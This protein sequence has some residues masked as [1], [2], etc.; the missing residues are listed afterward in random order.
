MGSTKPLRLIQHKKEAL[1]F[2]SF[3]S[4]GY[5]HVF[6]P[7]QYTEDM[8]DISLE[9]AR[10]HSRA[11]KVVDVGG[12]TGFT[13]LGVVRYVD[14]ENVTLLDQSPHQL[15]KARRKKALR[16][17]KIM[18]GD[19]EDLPFPTDTFDRY[20]SAGSIE[21]WPD[22]QRGIREAYRVL[23]ADGVACMIGP[24]RPTFWLS[25]FFADMWM[26]FPTEEEY[27]EWF[28]RAGFKDVELTRIGPR[29]YR[30]ARR[31]GLVIGCCVTGI[32]TQN[33]DSPLRLG[34]KAEDVSKPH[35]NPIFVFFRFLIGTIC[36]TYFFLVPIY[37][38]IKDKIVP[39]GRPI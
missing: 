10:L 2:Y 35:V 13:T 38:W 24:V 23:S 39:Q 26:L 32:K 33:G 16:G 3:I 20:V 4:F 18:E 30:G 8:R 12:G 7:G 37:M 29:W 22:P 36:A 31:H 9:H 11:L 14:P 28:E 21:Y 1:W 15:D 25:R 17:I 5:D 34:P 19:A 27:I 6:N